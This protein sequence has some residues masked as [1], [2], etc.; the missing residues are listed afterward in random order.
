MQIGEA[1]AASGVTAKMIRHYEANGLVPM[2]ERRSGNYR[3]Y[4]H[5]DI[6][7][8]AFVRRARALGF[9]MDKQNQTAPTA[10]GRLW[11]IKRRSESVGSS[12]QA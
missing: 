1:V 5:R 3:D 4:T 2:A 6:L 8:L 10:L 9:S 7:R 11:A 12:F